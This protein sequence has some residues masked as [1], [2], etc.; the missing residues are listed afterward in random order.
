MRILDVLLPV[1]HYIV[2]FNECTI[3]KLT[4]KNLGLEKGKKGMLAGDRDKRLTRECLSVIAIR[5]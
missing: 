5:D 4:K 1:T 2:N 3:H